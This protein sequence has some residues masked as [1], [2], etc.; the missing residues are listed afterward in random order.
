M[1]LAEADKAAMTPEFEKAVC[2][3]KLETAASEI[4]GRSGFILVYGSIEINCTIDAVF[5]A[6][7]EEISD[8]LNEFLFVCEG[9][10]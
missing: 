8:M 2:D 3:L 4:P 7:N 6:A 10:I 5:D 1:L 9:G